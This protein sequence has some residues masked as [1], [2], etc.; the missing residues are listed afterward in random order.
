MRTLI[1]LN[2]GLSRRDGGENKLAHTVETMKRHG[3][4]IMLAR[5]VKGVW[6]GK[7]ETTLACACFTDSPDIPR[8]LSLLAH[9]LDQTTFAIKTGGIGHLCPMVAGEAFSEDFW[10]DPQAPAV[11]AVEAARKAMTTIL[12]VNGWKRDSAKARAAEYALTIGVEAVAGPHAFF[13]ICRM[14]G[15]SILS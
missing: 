11:N 3:L 5:L 4:H 10:H 7:E 15:R 13:Q 1:E 8:D 2:V 6:Q 12:E 14:S 9:A